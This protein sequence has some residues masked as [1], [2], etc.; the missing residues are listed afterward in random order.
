MTIRALIADDST[1]IRDILRHHL[2][3]LGCR[4]VG[5]AENAAQ[6]LQLF[7]TLEPELVT[8]D[9][10]MPQ[11]DGLDALSAFRLMRQERPAAQIVVVS[12][13][14]FDG[15]RQTFLS[16]G[17]LDYLVKPFSRYAIDQVRR[18]LMWI[19][20]EVGGAEPASGGGS[21]PGAADGG[22]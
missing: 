22:S 11:V 7:R 4:I 14:P 15:T 21:P 18:K 13:M 5:E 6:A 17:A 1:F 16:E 20:P 8:L 2:E 10:V 19:F 9:V 3:R 12:A